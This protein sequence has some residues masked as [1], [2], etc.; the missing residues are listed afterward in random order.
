MLDTATIPIFEGFATAG[1]EALLLKGAGLA[2][3]L[4]QPDEVR[5]YVDI[6]VLVCPEHR[7]SAQQALAGLGYRNSSAALGVDEIGSRVVHAET[8]LG[9]PPGAPYPVMVELHRWLPGAKASPGAAW[10][11]L[12]R[13]RTTIAL[14][15]RAVPVLD[16]IGQALQ[17]AIHAAQHGPE[18]RKGLVELAL[19][20]ERWPSETWRAA[21]ALASEIDAMEAFAAGLRLIPEGQDIA[22]ALGLPPTDLL[23]WEI[24]NASTRPRGTF[25]LDALLES[26]GAARLAVLRRA[27][28]P[29]RG[30]VIAAHPWAYLGGVR[31]LAAY[32]LHIASAPRWA[33]KAWTYRR[34]AARLK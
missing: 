11:A 20:I 17:L 12:W 3:L 10:D 31:L 19:G 15:G 7:P 5:G 26:Q 22:Q 27:L 21:S 1:V 30:W 4:Y 8:W 2:R 28:L 32:L 33:A 23:E 18:F 29:S 16:R 14:E 13:R 25:H 9:T 6:D 24:I 34:R